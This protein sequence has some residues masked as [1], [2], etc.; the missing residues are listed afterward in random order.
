MSLYDPAKDLSVINGIQEAHGFK[1]GDLVE[2]TNPNGVTFAPRIVV[3]F[4]QE[5]EKRIYNYTLIPSGKRMSEEIIC[6]RTVY[7]N[8]DSPWY[9]VAPSSLRKL[10]EGEVV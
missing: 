2:Y 6:D 9:P 5:P 4:V 7:I 8:S 1:I 10:E 3:G